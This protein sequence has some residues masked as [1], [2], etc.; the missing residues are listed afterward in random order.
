MN[1]LSADALVDSLKRLDAR[2]ECA[3]NAKEFAMK[4]KDYQQ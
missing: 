2:P 3:S 4:I 1:T